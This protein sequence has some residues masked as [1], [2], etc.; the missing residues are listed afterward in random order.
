MARLEKLSVDKISFDKIHVNRWF[1]VANPTS[2]NRNFSKKWKLIQQLLRDKNIHFSSSIT[3]F[4]KHEIELVQNAVKQ[5]YRNFISVGGDGTLHHVVNAIMLQRYVKTSDITIA[6]IPL[7]TGND[8]IKTY[9][10]PNNIK[11]SIEIINQKKTILQD[12]GVL[13]TADQ[14]LTYFNNAAGLGYDAYIVNKLKKLKSF[15]SLSYLLAGIYGLFFYKKSIFSISFDDKKIE[16]NCLMTV[17]GLC[18]FSGGGMQFTK[19]VDASDGFFDITIA[20]NITFL[21]LVLNINK[22]YSG[23]IVHHKKCETYKTK[24]IC[25]Q[26]KNHKTFIQADGELIGTGKVTAKIL[27]KAIKFVVN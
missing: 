8:W 9:N 1:I 20:K 18:K 2:G 10:I 25:V 24:E 14:K 6:V 13:E 15:G 5:G 23:E 7:G 4:V 16:T 22:L 27:E 26:P 11:K 12:I 21:D 19:D 17:I 3:Q